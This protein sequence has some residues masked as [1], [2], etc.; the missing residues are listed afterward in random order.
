MNIY[1]LFFKKLLYLTQARI[2]YASSPALRDSAVFYK[3]G[4]LYKCRPE[5]GFV[6]EDYRGNVWNFMN[7]IAIVESFRR[8]PRLRYIAV[9]NS[10]VL[11]KNAVEEHRELVAAEAGHQVAAAHGAQQHTTYADVSSPS[12][13]PSLAARRR[14]AKKPPTS[15]AAVRPPASARIVY[16]SAS[17]TPA[18]RSASPHTHGWQQQFCTQQLPPTSS[19]DR[20]P[21]S[22]V[23]Q[24][25]VMSLS[26]ERA[27]KCAGGAPAPPPSRSRRRSRTRRTS[28]STGGRG[29]APTRAR[30]PD[31]TRD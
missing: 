3:S 5:R 7:S 8:S 23:D 15:S 28:R 29:S 18:R 4:S 10:N 1:S 14:R 30:A 31:A 16:V 24:V 9:V 19:P 22:E 2:R 25:V 13:M 20:Q 6:C 11:R 26:A 27:K 21:K 12:S 17:R